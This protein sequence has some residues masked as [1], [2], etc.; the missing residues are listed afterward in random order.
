MSKKKIESK[1]FVVATEGATTDGRI[2]ERN[3]IEQMANNYDP[4]NIL[5]ARINLEHF[6]T[7]LYI[8]D[9]AHSKSYGDVIALKAEQREDG[10]L[11]L[12]A[13]IAPTDDLINLN[14]QKQKVYTSIE[15][16]TNFADTGQAYLVGLAV[17][18][19][20]ASLGTEYLQFC[21]TAK[22]NPL[23]NRKQDKDNLFTESLETVWEFETSDNAFS[24]LEKVKAI[25]SKKTEQQ[26]QHF[27]E[28]RQS[29]ELISEEVQKSIEKQTALEQQLNQQQ[30]HIEQLNQQISQLTALTQQVASQPEASY[31]QRPLATGENADSGRFF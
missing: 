14:K 19:S 29:I 7:Y 24:L 21:S 8:D 10:K 18:D 30:Q 4:I 27:E 25:F 9:F 17:T 6:K 20:P 28:H 11:Q 2:I 12:F 31:Q 3:W 23:M 26:A 15:V 1:W 16:N 22:A 13:K 5:G